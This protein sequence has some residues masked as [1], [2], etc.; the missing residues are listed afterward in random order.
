[1][2]IPLV[3]DP[4]FRGFNRLECTKHYEVRENIY[5]IDSRKVLSYAE[6]KDFCAWIRLE[7]HITIVFTIVVFDLLAS[8]GVV[9]GHNW[10]SRIRGYIMNDGNYMILSNKKPL[11]ESQE[12]KG[13]PFSL[14]KKIKCCSEFSRFRDRKLCCPQYS[15]KSIL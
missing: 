4:I 15:T 13:N 3:E 9:L 10:C 2:V 12:N 5:A 7:T 6:I 11:L 14:R 1:M 8:Y